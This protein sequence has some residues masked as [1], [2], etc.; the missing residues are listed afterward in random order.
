MELLGKA[1]RHLAG[2]VPWLLLPLQTLLTLYPQK[3]LKSRSL[4][5]AVVVKVIAIP[6]VAQAGTLPLRPVRKLSR[7][8]Q[9][10]VAAAALFRVSQFRAAQL[11]AET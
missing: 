6:P 3:L 10:G 8:L 2:L 7:Q 1:L 11:Q 4:A 9:A 5:E